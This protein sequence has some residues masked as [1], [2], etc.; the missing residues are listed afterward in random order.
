MVRLI[1]LSEDYNGNVYCKV[2]NIIGSTLSFLYPLL[3]D[4][5]VMFLSI[6]GRFFGFN[7]YQAK[8]STILHRQID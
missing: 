2:L 5:D 3:F 8:Q 1:S 6:F 7:G 4:R